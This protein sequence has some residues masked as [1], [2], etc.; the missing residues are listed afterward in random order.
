MVKIRI[1]ALQCVS[2][3][4]VSSD[5]SLVGSGILSS[6]IWKKTCTSEVFKDEQM[7]PI[8]TLQEKIIDELQNYT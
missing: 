1:Y 8:N 6:P 5:L 3:A 4:L 7:L 2:D